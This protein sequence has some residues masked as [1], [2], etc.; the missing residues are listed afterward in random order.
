[1]ASAGLVVALAAVAPPGDGKTVEVEEAEARDV[2]AG[3]AVVVQESRSVAD[4]S[5][6]CRWQLIL[7]V[8]IAWNLPLDVAAS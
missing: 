3:A 8:V 7:G 2:I 1:M 5:I 6:V 4:G